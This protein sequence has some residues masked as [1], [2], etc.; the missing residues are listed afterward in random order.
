MGTVIFLTLSCSNLF[1]YTKDV[2][3]TPLPYSTHTPFKPLGML[4]KCIAVGV[5]VIAHCRP[6]EG[7]MR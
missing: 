1:S 2:H 3:I 4:L 5:C 7:E 6:E